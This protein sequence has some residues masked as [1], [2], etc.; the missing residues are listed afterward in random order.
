MAGSRPTSGGF[1]PLLALALAASWCGCAGAEKA[2]SDRRAIQ[3]ADQVMKALG[4]EPRWQ[5]LR[6]IAWTFENARGDTI[7]PGGRRH[8]WD[9]HSGMHRV[10]GR[11]RQGQSYVIIHHL[12]RGDGKAWMDGE[13]IEGDSLAKLVKRAKSLWTNDTYWM[14]MPYKLRDPGV[15][16]RYDGEVKEGGVT[17]DKLALSFEEVGETP[18][19][20]YWVFVNRANHRVE[21]WEFVLEGDPPPAK[22][23]TWEGWEQHGGLWFPTAHRSGENTLY[24]RAV[25]VMTDLPTAAFAAP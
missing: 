19:D 3:V 24:T 7:R 16:L 23:W 6:G 11:N 15:R 5:A 1:G 12:D 18:G 22:T 8:M 21:K 25:E 14:L 13:A 9:K 17:W 10:E 20:R 4:G 2:D